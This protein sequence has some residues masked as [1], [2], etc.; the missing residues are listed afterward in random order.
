MLIPVQG[1][2]M[3][4]S[5]L[6]SLHINHPAI[7]SIEG[8]SWLPEVFFTVINSWLIGVSIY[9]C[10]WIEAYISRISLILKQKHYPL[11]TMTINPM[12]KIYASLSAGER[13]S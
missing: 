8:T 4:K 2:G 6:A 13:R 7:Y 10:G 1:P 11:C 3:V 9:T 12:L 5:L